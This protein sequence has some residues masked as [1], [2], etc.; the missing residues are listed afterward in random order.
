[1]V[2]ASVRAEW[3]VLLLIWLVLAVIGAAAVAGPRLLTRAESASL[4]RAIDQATPAARRMSIQ[5]IDGFPAGDLADPFAEPRARV[6]AVAARI[7][8]A[9]LAR[10]GAP[11]LVAD[12]NRFEIVGIGVTDAAIVGSA[13]E[14][15]PPPLPTYLTFRVHPD[16]ADHSALVAGR[17]PEPTVRRVGDLE[18]FEFALSPESADQLGWAIGDRLLLGPDTADLVTRQFNIGLPRPFVAELVG[19]RALEPPEDPFWAGDQRLHRPTVVDTNAGANIFA[20]GIAVPVQ[21]PTRPFLLGGSG[22]FAIEQRRDLEH[23]AIDLAN[24][25]PTLDGLT[26]L[27][28]AF[29]EQPTLARPGVVAPLGPVL[30]VELDQQR[31][32]RATLLLA[33]VGVFGVALA[34]LVQLVVVSFARRRPWLTVARARGASRCHVI[35]GAAVE[36]GV[37]A[38]TAVTAGGL[39]SALMV[40]GATSSMEVALVAGVWLGAVAASSSVAAAEVL[41]PVTVALGSPNRPALARWGRIA[42]MMLVAVAA[43]SFVT[44]RRRGVEAGSGGPDLLTVALPVLVALALVWLTRWVLPAIV[45]RVARRGLGLAPGRLVGLRR[46]ADAPAA[47]TA[48]VTVLVLSL[49][50]AGLGMAID[51][52]IDEGAVD[53]SWLAVGSPYRIV[54]RAESV[55]AAIGQIEGATVAASGSTRINVAIRADAANVQFATV[56][57]AAITAL[58]AGTVAD[59]RY[60]SAMTAL[61]ADGRV[62]VVASERISG[63]RVRPGDLI[64]GAGSRTDQTFVVVETRSEA[65]GRRND[66]LIADRGVTAQ[67]TGTTAAFNA[68]AIDVPDIAVPELRAIADASGETL[69]TRSGA[70]DEQRSDPLARAVRSG[71]LAASLLAVLLALVALVAIAVVTARQRRREVVILA[72]LGADD[73]EVGRA[74]AAELVPAAI[75]GVV[76]GSLVGSF[77]VLAFDGR[78]DLSAFAGG[79]SVAIRPAPVAVVAVAALLMLVCVVLIVALVRRI[80]RAPVGEILRIEGAA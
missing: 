23:G 72:L 1:M 80:V 28:A 70:L 60:P 32:A 29:A 64:D 4:D 8:D 51:R 16:L 17:D 43:A 55:A 10:Y 21:M 62:P 39:A 58:T 47:T 40:G 18:V 69:V 5:V 46:V 36:M 25:E 74:V 37:A 45:R 27:S 77:V 35:V 53:A 12:T 63:V 33:A 26:A 75:A 41:R 3:P 34:A 54:T 24:V 30:A 22:A 76:G 56:D 78:Y 61:D 38:A 44:F 19:L 79:S 67:A 59:P 66:W 65:F 48:I 31:V 13:D 73:L 20:F 9:V 15:P 42:G 71:Y 6:D 52:S 7:D 2:G 14:I 49:T 57:V 11:R 68:L 50:V